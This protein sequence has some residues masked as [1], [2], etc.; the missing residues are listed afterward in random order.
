MEIIENN[1]STSYLTVKVLS[2]NIELP[3]GSTIVAYVPLNTKKLSKEA[4]KRRKYNTF[5]YYRLRDGTI[6]KGLFL[7]SDVFL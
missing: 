3:N 5:S 4:A 7:N 6:L 1:A 2:N